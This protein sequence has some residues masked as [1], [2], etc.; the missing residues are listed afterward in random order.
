MRKYWTKVRLKPRR[1]SYKFCS[2]M[3]NVKRLSC[4]Q[5]TSLSW[6]YSTPCVKLS[7]AGMPWLLHFHHLGVFNETQVLHEQM[8][9]QGFFAGTYS[10]ARI[11]RSAGF[12]NHGGSPL[13]TISFCTLKPEPRGLCCPVLLGMEPGPLFELHLQKF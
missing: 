8:E 10:L 5:H 1:I 11:L 3:S 6:K 12:L 13:T 4:L 9:S 7:L 2:F